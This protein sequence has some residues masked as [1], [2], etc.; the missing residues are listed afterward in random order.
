MSDRSA[1]VQIAGKQVRVHEN[2]VIKVPLLADEVGSSVEFDQVLLVSDGD[3]RVGTPVLDG[4]KVVAEVVEHGRDKKIRV[5]RMK[6]RKTMRRTRG[7]RQHFTQIRITA[8]QA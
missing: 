7:H 1:V 3:V 6:R 5:F 2:D 8:I 4:A